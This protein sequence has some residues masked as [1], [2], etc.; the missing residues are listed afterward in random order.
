MQVCVHCRNGQG[1]RGRQGRQTW[2]YAYW[3]ITPKTTDW[4]YQTYR[5]RFGIETSYR[6]LHQARIP[7]T[8]RLPTLRLRFVGI[9]LFLRNLWVWVH[10]HQLATSRRGGRILNLHLLPF[11]TLLMWLAHVVELT[12]G[13]NDS[14]V[15]HHL[16]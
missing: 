16:N 6:Q 7:T 11:E 3:G 10:W 14:V 4:V 12:F 8:T 9:A 5:L 13:F 1:R 15:I 2:V